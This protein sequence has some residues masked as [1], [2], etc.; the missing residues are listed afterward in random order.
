MDE[1]I[2]IMKRNNGLFATVSGNSSRDGNAAYNENLSRKR[3]ESV[4]NY[5]KS[6]GIGLERI[7]L[8]SAGI[9]KESD[10]LIYGRRVDIVV[11]P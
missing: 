5:L 8:K 3:A 11:E 6:A 1:I 10:L 2:S 9:D 4:Q 7:I